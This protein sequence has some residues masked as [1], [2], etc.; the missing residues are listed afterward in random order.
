MLS[1]SKDKTLKYFTAALNM[2]KLTASLA[3]RDLL[4]T[5]QSP[6]TLSF[7]QISNDTSM[8]NTRRLTAYAGIVYACK[9]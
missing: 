4:I 8:Q 6:G 7:R 2:A 3:Q 9:S 5:K 1:A